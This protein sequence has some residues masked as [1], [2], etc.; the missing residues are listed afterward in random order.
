MKCIRIKH[1]NFVL[2]KLVPANQMI[3][4]RNFIQQQFPNQNKFEPQMIT[5]I[6]NQQ[7][8]RLNFEQFLNV[9]QQFTDNSISES[10]K[11]TY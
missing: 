4:H 10:T 8:N 2:R 5:P 3:K 9:T 6:N 7:D 1:R 11:H